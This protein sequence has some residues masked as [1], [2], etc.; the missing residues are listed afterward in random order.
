MLT[1]AA[2]PRQRTWVDLCHVAVVTAVCV[3]CMVVRSAAYA[4][5]ALEHEQDQLV[6]QDAALRVGWLL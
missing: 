2:A 6:L 1:A 5:H 3:A 4:E